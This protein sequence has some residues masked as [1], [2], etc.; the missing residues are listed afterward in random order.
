MSHVHADEDDEVIRE[1]DVYVT[2]EGFPLYLAQF[3]L[4][5]VYADPLNVKSAKYKQHHHH[6]EL[7]VP[8]SNQITSSFESSNMQ[9]DNFQKYVSHVVSS[10]N[11]LA[12]GF[13]AE[14]TLYLSPISQT[15]QFR[16]SL[17]QSNGMTKL[18][19]MEI[20]QDIDAYEEEEAAA[21]GTSSANAEN[22]QQV[23]L[24]RKESERAQSAR[25]QSYSYLK[26]QL[27]AEPWRGMKVFPIGKG[28]HCNVTFSDSCFT[29]RF[30]GSEVSD[31]KFVELAQSVGDVMIVDDV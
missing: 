4:K 9:S 6:I 2:N 18:E 3:P 11:T 27:E 30:V 13:I 14:D 16:P 24:K 20:T 7:H 17:K 1:I 25:L 21:A 5:P 10:Q 26:Q 19:A 31:G 12:S 28:Y 22:V 15:L 8:Y 23:Q 29:H